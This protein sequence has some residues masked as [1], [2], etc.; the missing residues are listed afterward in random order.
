[1]ENREGKTSLHDAARNSLEAVAWLLLEKG[2][3]CRWQGCGGTDGASDGNRQA[4]FRIRKYP[5][6]E[7]WEELGDELNW[8]LYNLFRQTLRRGSRCYGQC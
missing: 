3:S 2:G 6:R 7:L 5:G 4:S 1:V 8:L